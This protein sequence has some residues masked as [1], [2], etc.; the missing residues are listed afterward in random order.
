M[1][2]MGKNYTIGN[3]I[4]TYGAEYVR[5]YG[6]NDQ[7]KSAYDETVK[8][9]YKV[10]KKIGT[11]SYSKAEKGAYDGLH[12]SNVEPAGRVN[13]EGRRKP[14]PKDVKQKLS[15]PE[16]SIPKP[17][18]VKNTP[19]SNTT[20][21]FD[22]ATIPPPY[23]ETDI[24]PKDES[25]KSK[26][27][28][29]RKPEELTETIGNY[30]YIDQKSVS[31]PVRLLPDGNYINNYTQEIIGSDEARKILEY[32][33]YTP[34]ELM[35]LGIFF[36]AMIIIG[37]RLLIIGPAIFIIWGIYTSMR[38]MTTMEKYVGSV[39]LKCPIPADSEELSDYKK[40]GTLY[41]F[42]GIIM[43]IMQAYVDLPSL[44]F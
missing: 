37:Y 29:K 26:A 24:L 14:I 22:K 34:K 32:A 39:V 20:I 3:Y 16:I 41:V 6:L 30:D 27:I 44:S 15:K 13:A 25:S 5:S 1:A 8:E 10:S 28:P 43:G 19:P 12:P 2:N 23:K 7:Q 21:S 33:G 36:F 11:R 31:N 17:E 40:R 18:V 38:K 42:I 4:K 35:K 9:Y